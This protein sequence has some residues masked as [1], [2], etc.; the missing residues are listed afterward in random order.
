MHAFVAQKYAL[1][2]YMRRFSCMRY[3]RPLRL[4]LI[5]QN[6]DQGTFNYYS[7]FN[8]KKWI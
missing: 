4:N 1:R 2:A 7:I 3:R 8:K 5:P 6:V